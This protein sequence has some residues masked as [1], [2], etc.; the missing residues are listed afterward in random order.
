MPKPLRDAWLVALIQLVQMRRQVY[1]FALVM[2]LFPL[3]TLFFARFMTPEGFEPSQRL[4]AGA[5][6]FGL[7]ISTV[8]GVAQMIALD[9]FEF[10]QRLIVAMPVHQ[11]S[12][13][14]GMVLVG[15]LQ[16][17]VQAAILLPLAPLFGIDIQLSAW[18]IP[19]ALLTA[20]SMTGV[21]LMVGTWAP[22]QQ[23]GNLTANVAGILVVLISPVFYPISR[24][25][26]WLQVPARLSPYTHAG[27]AFDR[28]LSG[29]GGFHGEMAILAAITLLTLSVGMA[30]MRWRQ[31]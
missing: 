15:S 21:G 16:G 25:P 11:V 24:L 23:S 12:Y 31:A 7:G 27:E 22:S 17:L 20:V 9:R 1:L 26:E 29:A 5:V 19:L 2:M 10:H 28:V 30:G 4:I 13:G 8:N 14:A 18:L 3:A 6:V